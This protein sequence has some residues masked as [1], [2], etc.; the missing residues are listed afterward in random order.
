MPCASCYIL[1][2]WWSLLFFAPFYCYSPRHA[3]SRFDSRL[4]LLARFPASCCFS[5]SSLFHLECCLPWCSG[6]TVSFIRRIPHGG[7]SA[8]PL[9]LLCLCRFQLLRYS[10]ATQADTSAGVWPLPLHCE[11]SSQRSRFPDLRR[12]CFAAKGLT[13]R[14]SEPRPAPMRTFGIVRSSSLRPRS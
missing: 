11:S 10:V 1:R 8:F 5:S 4:R 3:V 7:S 14:C 13:R 6:R 9:S 12:N 2:A